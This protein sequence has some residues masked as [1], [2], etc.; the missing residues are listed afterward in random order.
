MTNRTTLD[1]RPRC[2]SSLNSDWGTGAPRKITSHSTA[3]TA[4]LASVRAKM[5]R[6]SRWAFGKK[7][8]PSMLFTVAMATGMRNIARQCPASPIAAQRRCAERQ[9]YY[10]VRE[11]QPAYY[12]WHLWT[13]RRDH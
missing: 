9:H 10:S 7:I 11:H 5:P 8:T 4:K 3:A 1:V 12:T 2:G 6:Q 13:V